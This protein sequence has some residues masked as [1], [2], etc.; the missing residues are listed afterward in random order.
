MSAL[1]RASA[2]AVA[3]LL[4]WSIAGPAAP[5]AA[6]QQAAAA[7]DG[8]RA[9]PPVDGIGVLHVQRNVYVLVG[10]GSNVTVQIG[11]EGILVVDTQSGTASDRLVRA[12]QSLSDKPLRW[13]INTHF[14]RDHTGGNEAI[15]RAGASIRQNAFGSGRNFPGTL[16]AGT[17]IVA[18]E[19]VLTRMSAPTGAAAPTPQRAWPV[20]TYFGEGRELFFNGEAV[21]VIHQPRAHTD[22]DSVVY[23]RY[24]DVVSTGDIFV[25]T[26]YPVIDE[27]AGGT[28][29]GVIDGLNRIIDLAIPREKQEGGT[30]VVPG[31][32]RITDE[33][34]VVYYR[35]MVTIIRDRVQD[36]IKRGMTLE[37]VKAARPTAGYD[38]R[39][40]TPSWTADMF[41]EAVYRTLAPA[42]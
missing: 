34:D 22:G 25:T 23:F 39:W 27:Q 19:S 2:V 4:A 20:A 3:T 26:G 42:S 12:I 41:V 24:S 9:L 40:A 29:N 38:R 33:A 14:H 21:Q 37:Q 10:E 8:P 15:E 30:Y 7:A 6:G 16:P 17:T 13:A 31:H 28:I 18:H 5:R 1:S 11:D 35:N 32:G 36:M